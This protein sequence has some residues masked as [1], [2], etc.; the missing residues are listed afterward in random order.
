[1]PQPAPFLVDPI[2]DTQLLVATCRVW[3]GP[4][5]S[6]WTPANAISPVLSGAG[7][8]VSCNGNALI[9]SMAAMPLASGGEIIYLGMYGSA[10]NGSLL[11]GHVL[12]SLA[13]RHFESV[14]MS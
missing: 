14:K 4:A 6:G 7:T 13:K 2:D 11:P 1:M 8:A 9:R 5:G 10:T 12:V 3:R